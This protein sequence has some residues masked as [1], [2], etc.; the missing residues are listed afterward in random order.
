MSRSASR[1]RA[2]AGAAAASRKHASAISERPTRS[3]G[4]RCGAPHPSVRCCSSAAAMAAARCCGWGGWGDAPRPRSSRESCHGVFG[5]TRAPCR[6][7]LELGCA[8]RASRLGRDLNAERGDPRDLRFRRRRAAGNGCYHGQKLCPV[9]RPARGA[10]RGGGERWVARWARCRECLE[11]AGLPVHAAERIR[12]PYV[13]PGAK[14][15]PKLAPPPE[16]WG[17]GCCKHRQPPA[18]T[19][20]LAAKPTHT[21]AHPMHAQL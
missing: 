4:Q 8:V 13:N 11:P 7:L 12:E 14:A 17:A 16:N 2:A 19:N 20:H 21:H 3:P 10:A 18:K 5:G 15:P 9:S 1:A 6:C